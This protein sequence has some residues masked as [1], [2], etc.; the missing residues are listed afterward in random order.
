MSIR[1]LIARRRRIHAEARS[2]PLGALR[3]QGLMDLVGLRL[4]PAAT[5][6]ILAFLHSHHVGEAVIVSAAMLAALQLI[7]R[8]RFP[9]TLMPAARVGLGLAAPVLAALTMLGV[10]ALVGHPAD[11]E[12][13]VAAVVGAWLTLG[14]GGWM[15][16]RIERTAS[17]RVAVVGSPRFAQDLRDELRMTGVRA[18]EVIGWFGP[19]GPYQRHDDGPRWLGSLDNVRG[20]VLVNKVDLV[21]CAADR[22]S[23]PGAGPGEGAW[24]RVAGACLDLPLRMIGANQFYED[25]LGHVPIGTID[26]A[27]YRYVLHPRFQSA[28]PLSKRALDVALGVTIGLLTAP[29]I[30]VAALLVKLVDGGPVVYRQ[31]RLGEHGEPF[32]ML[33]LRTMTVDS[34]ADGARWAVADDTRV[35]RV[36]RFLRR[37]HIDELPQTWNILRGDMTLVGPRPERPQMVSELERQY[38]HYTRR[39][40]YKP[41]IAGWAQLRCG[42][43]GSELGTGWKL[44][45]DLFYIKHRSVLGDLLIVL[46]TAFETFRDAHRALRTPGERFILEERAHS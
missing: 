11:G 22:E 29:L 25:L 26:Q 46:E 16:T 4:A 8:S 15:K 40:L 12:E 9:L 33:K 19:E 13:F 23:G 3:A 24:E 38:S 42:Y 14:L 5:A 21:V 37:T 7:E 39:H 17:A 27:W 36:G 30:A 34:E 41:G 18:Y 10:T 6:G 45:H 32:E 35:T 44:C 20:A 1:G 2:R 28:E 43:A 31:I